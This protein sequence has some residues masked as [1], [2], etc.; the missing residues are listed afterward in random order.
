[1]KFNVLQG[2]NTE[3]FTLIMKF[4]VQ[5]QNYVHLLFTVLMLLGDIFLKL[6][7]YNGTMKD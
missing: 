6:R 5:K 4:I 2:K 1:M 7:R 3:L